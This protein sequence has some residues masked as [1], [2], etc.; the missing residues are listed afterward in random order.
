MVSCLTATAAAQGSCEFDSDGI[1]DIVTASQ[2]DTG[3]TFSVLYSASDASSELGTIQKSE[4]TAVVANFLAATTPQIGVLSADYD[5]GLIDWAI[6][7]QSDQSRSAQLGNGGDT[8][9]VGADLNGDGATDAI[10]VGVQKFRLVWQID[11]ALFGSD[12]ATR[13]TIRW[14]SKSEQPFF[15]SLDGSKDL[16]AVLRRF[17]GRFVVRTYDLESGATG[18]YEGLGTFG[19]AR[20][21]PRPHPIKVSDGSDHLVVSEVVEDATLLTFFNPVAGSTSTKT[22]AAVG[23]VLIGN[24]TADPGEE[25]AV[26]SES[27]LVIYNPG[28]DLITEMVAPTTGLVDGLEFSRVIGPTPTPTPSY[29]SAPP[30]LDTVCAQRSSIAPGELLIKSEISDHI[31]NPADPRTS[32]YTL[33]C[34]KQCPKNLN[35]ADF[36]YADGLYAGSVG[37]YG[38]FR[39][40]GKPRLYGAAGEAPQH[41]V[42]IIAP[43]AKLIG[44]G[45][46]YMQMSKETTGSATVCKEF[47]PKGR[48]GGL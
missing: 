36:F 27:G 44:N 26:Q 25:V 32:G 3:T 19:T 48:N 8:V 31:S 34:A 35:K 21:R 38:T 1:S 4:G 47:N 23:A 42:S 45:K 12:S 30:G 28:T 15:F 10:S 22:L 37:Y 2:S 13:R 43:A 14:G 29:P 9:V 20:P 7:D 5:T 33:V 17:N 18:R 11:T 41:F 39:G 6:L 24:Y 46:L 16:L 40:N